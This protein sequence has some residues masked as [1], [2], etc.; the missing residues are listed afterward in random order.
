MVVADVVDDGGHRVVTEIEEAD[1]TAAFVHVDTSDEREVDAMVAFALET[2]GALDLAQNNAGIGYPP[3]P[4]HELATA[5]WDRV[6]GTDRRG[7]FFRL[8]GELGHVVSA[9]S[10]AIVNTPSGAGQKVSLNLDAYVASKHAVVG[11]TRNAGLAYSG[12]GIRVNAVAPGTTRKPAMA[13]FPQELQDQWAAHIPLHRMAE[14]SEVASIVAF[15]LSDEASC[16]TGSTYE[17]DGAFLQLRQ[18]AQIDE[19]KSVVRVELVVATVHQGRFP[20][21]PAGWALG[22]L[23]FRRDLGVDPLD[24]RD[25]PEFDRDTPTAPGYPSVWRSYGTAVKGQVGR[26]LDAASGYPVL[27]SD[28][29]YGFIAPLKIYSITSLW[30]SDT[31][32]WCSRATAMSPR[33]PA[34]FGPGPGDHEHLGVHTSHSFE[35]A[36]ENSSRGGLRQPAIHVDR[37]PC[38]EVLSSILRPPFSSSLVWRLHVRADRLRDPVDLTVVEP[39]PIGRSP[40]RYVADMDSMDPSRADRPG[41]LWGA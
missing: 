25:E 23:R 22:R 5:E 40:S 11:L 8:R 2:Y 3:T 35:Q 26:R 37:S 38:R 9:G 32:R 7:T 24:L 19:R 41:A 33:N 28:H 30:N 14:P 4:L 34:W 6:T 36:A 12:L 21:L 27:S 18:M 1:G 17:V 39:V 20:D 31:S 13:S 10:G 29:N 16:V 15:L